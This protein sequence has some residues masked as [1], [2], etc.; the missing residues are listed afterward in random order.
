MSKDKKRVS[1]D[2]EDL[3][4][5][6]GDRLQKQRA[7]D[8]KDEEQAGRDDEVKEQESAGKES[9]ESEDSE[10]SEEA[11]KTGREASS[12]EETAAEEE[13]PSWDD[14]REP[15]LTS[16]TINPDMEDNYDD[17]RRTFR[18][19]LNLTLSKQQAIDLGWKLLNHLDPRFF[20][21]VRATCSPEDNLI[22]ALKEII[23]EYY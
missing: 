10:V 2:S 8:R 17:I 1:S 12:A 21:E 22:E 19:E 3:L 9:K 23:D 16:Y 6:I 11:K 13:I 20:E 7:K 18:R 15:Y 5:N 4:K 14:N